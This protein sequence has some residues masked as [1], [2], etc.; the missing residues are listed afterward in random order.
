MSTC[1]FYQPRR[2][3]ISAVYVNDRIIFDVVEEKLFKNGFQ[4]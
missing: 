1:L 2:M 4:V 3:R